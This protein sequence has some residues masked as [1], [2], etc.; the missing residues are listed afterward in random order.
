MGLGARLALIFAVV[1]AATAMLVG[2]ASYATTNRQVLAEVDDF[3][4]ERADDIAGGGRDQ[5]KGPRDERAIAPAVGPD[6]EV[7]VL[8]R[9]GE[10]VS[11][12]GASLPVEA[13]DRELAQQDKRAIYRTVTI[14]GSNYRMISEHLPGGG[15]VQVARSLDESA[16][17]LGVLQTRLVLVAGALALAA[18]GAGWVVAQRTTRPLRTLTGAVDE[19]AATQDFTVPVS[20]YGSDEV[21]R[22]AR[23]FNGML[24]TLRTSRQ[25]QHQLVEDAAHELRTP[26]T[27]VT[28]NVDWLIH[29][30]DLDAETRT[31][32][33]TS[34]RRELG[35]L[36]NLMAEIVELATESREPAEMV[37]T[38]LAHLV[39]KLVEQFE[40]RTG[41]PV[42]VDVQPVVVAGD[43]RS[44]T[45]AVNNLLTNADKYSPEA[46][47][48]AVEVG[49]DGVFVDDAGPGI[50]QAEH[51]LIF[52]RFYRRA[53][54]R[55]RP[56]SGLGLAIVA[57]IVEQHAGTTEVATSPLGGARIGFSLP[58]LPA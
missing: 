38:D 15:V 52:D 6:A 43:A 53:E 45:R 9:D 55:S 42:T 4:E 46:Q 44:L 51:E 30:S 14:D 1:A 40:Q 54:D 19:V 16:S 22:L 50:P 18:A 12:S 56:G 3:L 24:E 57:E 17:L 29:A 7:Q 39:E 48:I 34:V 20:T 27:S 26:L 10:V 5:P 49:P 41:R 35:E 33:L 11:I 58:V 32:T 23:G 47:A 25:Q 8:D 2:G 28:A 13:A 31:A 21:G 36:N 37:P